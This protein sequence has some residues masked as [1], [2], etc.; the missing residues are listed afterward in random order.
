MTSS[1][2]RNVTLLH[3][4]AII[5][6]C[7]IGS[8][9]FITPQLVYVNVGSV[10]GTLVLWS[11]SGVY[12]CLLCWCYMELGT[13]M[14]SSG[15]EYVY[16]Y[17]V[18]GSWAG[19]LAWWIGFVVVTPASCG[20]IAQTAGVYL[21]TAVGRPGDKILCVLTADLIISFLFYINI[22]ST[23][24]SLVLNTFL[25]FC[26]VAALAFII[27]TG[28]IHLLLGNTENF[29]NVF[30]GTTTSVALLVTAFL[31]CFFNYVG[32]EMIVNISE[33]IIN[34]K[35]NLPIAMVISMLLV[36]A[37]YFLTN[38]AYFAVLSPSDLATSSAVALSLTTNSFHS[39]VMT[40]ILSA[41]VAMS[42]TGTLN[43]SY[44]T[45]SRIVFACAR[46]KQIPECLAMTGIHNGVPLCFVLLQH[47]L[48]VMFSLIPDLSIPISITSFAAVLKVFLSIVALLVIKWQNTETDAPVRIPW[49]FAGLAALLQVV[50][51][52]L[53]IYGDP[54]VNGAAL[55][56]CVIGIP[57][58]GII[59]E[60]QKN[61]VTCCAFGWCFFKPAQVLT[62]VDSFQSGASPSY[63]KHF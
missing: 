53:A 47:G 54:W 30:D 18:L 21:A 19:F 56:I 6:S 40:S 63:R 29:E 51:M 37:I 1:T 58:Y 11:V 38:V 48:F 62:S 14:P 52:G 17:T 60:F 27:V 35:R 57:V 50:I 46:N 36:M 28:V 32:W 10:G 41:C 44:L 59:L 8:G 3:A 33:E 43:S 12:V 7:V 26:K 42:C 61:D 25:T 20:A 31:D 39:I 22:E 49:I 13:L 45:S 34:P 55:L 5:V 15:G 24:A 23:R 2:K 9:I 4:V 16:S